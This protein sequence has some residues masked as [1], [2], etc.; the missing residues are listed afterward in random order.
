MFTEITTRK[1]WVYFAPYTQF[2]SQPT[3]K[4]ASSLIGGS[5][6]FESE[7]PACLRIKQVCG[8]AMQ[9]ATSVGFF[10]LPYKY[11]LCCSRGTTE[12][13]PT[14]CKRL[15]LLQ[16]TE[17]TWQTSSN[18]TEIVSELGGVLNQF[19]DSSTVFLHGTRNQI[20]MRIWILSCSVASRFYFSFNQHILCTAAMRISID[21]SQPH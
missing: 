20:P 14:I 3:I 8:I 4:R 18:C 21:N 6:C 1:T 2:F 12:T 5:H 9:T 17:S 15:L 16:V 19:P 11:Y 13:N 10:R 7:F